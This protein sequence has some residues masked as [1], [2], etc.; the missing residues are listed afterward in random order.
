[1]NQLLV[2]HLNIFKPCLYVIRIG[3]TENSKDHL[4]LGAQVFAHNGTVQAIF[5]PGRGLEAAGTGVKTDRFFRE[6]CGSGGNI[7]IYNI[8][9]I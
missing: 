2:S 3:V 4:V 5:P 6:L 9:Y 8:I 7:Y 1:M